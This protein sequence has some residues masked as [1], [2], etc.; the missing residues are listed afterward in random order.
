MLNPAAS[1][2][3]DLAS[4]GD[5]RHAPGDW[6]AV[7]A[8]LDSDGIAVTPPLLSE[9]ECQQAR[10]W[11]GDPERFRSTVV[12]QRHGFGRGTYRYF[13]D[14]LPGLVRE[15]REWLYPPLAHIAN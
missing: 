10:A 7:R 13:A 5:A 8:R 14:P 3:D 4:D 11:F 6:A 1:L 15:L 9:A 2:F 12:M